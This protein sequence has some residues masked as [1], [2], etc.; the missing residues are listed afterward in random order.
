MRDIIVGT[1]VAVYTVNA[2]GKPIRCRFKGVVT[3]VVNDLHFDGAS[4]C[5]RAYSGLVEWLPLVCI[6][7]G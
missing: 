4:Y 3:R 2:E 7:P 6:R 1:K 5:V